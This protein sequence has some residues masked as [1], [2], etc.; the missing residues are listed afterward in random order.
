LE[1]QRLDRHGGLAHGHWHHGL[2]LSLRGGAPRLTDGHTYY[3]ESRAT[4]NAGN[5]E[6]IFGANNFTYAESAPAQPVPTSTTHINPA[7]WYNN[8][9]PSFEWDEPASTVAIDGYSVALDPY[10]GTIPDTSM[11]TEELTYD[12]AT[13]PDGVW[14]FHVRAV[15]IA[16]IWGPAGHVRVNID[17]TAPQAPASV[18]E[19]SPDVDWHAGG[20]ITVYWS[21]V[22][23]TGSGITYSL[24]RCVNGGL[25]GACSSGW[26]PVAT[27]ITATQRINAIGITDGTT[28]RYRVRATN[29]VLL[30]G[31][32]GES[33]GLTIDHQTPGTPG[34]VFEDA[35]SEPDRDFHS[36]A[37]GAVT[38]RWDAVSNTGSGITYELR[39]Q[40][41]PP[42]GPAGA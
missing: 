12:A 33:D 3:V 37:N 30:S 22:P 10:P 27:G 8:S 25:S 34:G 14:Y 21:T 36:S 41:T 16:G 19:E 11:D 42:G 6:T 5:V 40:V 31:G 7:L 26:A 32:W 15:N 23:N 28:V 24:E 1:W 13:T 9:L 29:G 17:T 2:V 38:V 18:S 4:D 35:A 39:K 20:S